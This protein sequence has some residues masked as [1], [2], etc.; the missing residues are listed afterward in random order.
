MITRS[1]VDFSPLLA[2]VMTIA[3]ECDSQLKQT[4]NGFI[5][6]ASQVAAQRVMCRELPPAINREARR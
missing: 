1:T 2:D 5:G 3:D 6:R 4:T